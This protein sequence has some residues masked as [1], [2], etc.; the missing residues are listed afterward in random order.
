MEFQ[1]FIGGYNSGHFEVVLKN[2]E[3]HFSVSDYP[4]RI[5]QQEP[6]HIIP[7]E[8]DIAWQNLV[9]YID[10]LI[11][12]RKYET[13]IMD[14]TQWELTFKSESKKMKC[15]GSNAFP[16]EFDNFVKLLRKI[17]AKN[18]IPNELLRNF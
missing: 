15:Y 18:K 17:T 3:L 12:R 6:T 5:E 4:I 13:D 7:I 14:G 11:W 10:G 1:F 16:T 2:C 9:K 8:G